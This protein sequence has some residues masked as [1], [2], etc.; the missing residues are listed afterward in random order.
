M[1]HTIEAVRYQPVLPRGE[2]PIA[3][4]EPGLWGVT[5]RIRAIWGRYRTQRALKSLE[6]RLLVDIGL[7]RDQIAELRAGRMPELPVKH[8]D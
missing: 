7:N 2:H 6:D 5:G 8:R 1:S 4:P 3:I